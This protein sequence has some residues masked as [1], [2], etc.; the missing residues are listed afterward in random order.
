MFDKEKEFL[1]LDVSNDLL[2]CM[3]EEFEKELVFLDE[4]NLEPMYYTNES[5]EL[6]LEKDEPK[7][8]PKFEDLF[9]NTSYI[10]GLEIEIPAVME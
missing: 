1:K 3:K 9:Q 8:S 10:N 7:E 2:K 4:L 5:I 6:T